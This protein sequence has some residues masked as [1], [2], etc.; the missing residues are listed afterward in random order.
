M[1]ES[2]LLI[3]ICAL[4]L[5]LIIESFYFIFKSEWPEQYFGKNDIQFQLVQRSFLR[6][7]TFRFMP[8]FIIV[9]FYGAV[10][11]KL[12]SNYFISQYACLIGG[13][14]Y[15]VYRHG[16]AIVQ[17]ILN[18]GIKVEL[19]KANQILLHSFFI[20]TNFILIFLTTFIIKLPII[21]EA[22]PSIDGLRDEIWGSA[23]T[24]YLGI[25][26]WEIYKRGID[27]SHDSW[28]DALESVEKKLKGKKAKYLNEIIHHSQEFEASA[29]LIYSTLLVEHLQRPSWFRTLEKIKS[30]LFKKGS[31]GIMQTQSPK[32]L[33][34]LESIYLAIQDYFQNTR[35]IDYLD[36]LDAEEAIKELLKNYNDN[37]DFVELVLIAYQRY[38]D[39]ID[40]D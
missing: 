2:A 18:K 5:F 10:L 39:N 9:L 32:P 1:L 14:A 15:L 26:I 13:I 37:P 29:V 19:N 8:L 36:Y 21:Q 17:I 40:L 38:K 7:L 11:F 3:I 33:N 16:K 31:Y 4:L 34:D 20:A 25:L 6:I 23:I 30:T 24:A 27:S 22:I 35:Y 12:T 28:I